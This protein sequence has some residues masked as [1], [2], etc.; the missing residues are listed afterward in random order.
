VRLARALAA[1]PARA[2]DV[3]AAG[4]IVDACDR[5]TDSLDTLVNE[6]RRQLGA[7]RDSVAPHE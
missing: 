3:E 7:A 2:G 6:L 1:E 5:I 4:A